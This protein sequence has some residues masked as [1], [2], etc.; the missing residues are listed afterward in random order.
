MRKVNSCLEKSE[1]HPENSICG[2]KQWEVR[3]SLAQA[4]EA[5]MLLRRQLFIQVPKL[6]LRRKDVVSVPI[7]INLLKQLNCGQLSEPVEKGRL[8]K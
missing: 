3:G 1:D 5:L 8:I 4:G 2:G 7:C 6:P